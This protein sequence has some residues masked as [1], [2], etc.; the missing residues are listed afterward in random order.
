MSM[1]YNLDAKGDGIKK[2]PLVSSHHV[3]FENIGCAREAEVLK[4]LSS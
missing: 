1:I 3:T 2:A 4:I